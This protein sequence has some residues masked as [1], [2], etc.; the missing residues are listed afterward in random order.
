MY[1]SDTRWF[2]NW[3][4]SVSSQS[5]GREETDKNWQKL[6]FL[7]WFLWELSENWA[8]TEAE[9]APLVFENRTKTSL[10]KLPP[11]TSLEKLVFKTGFA[12]LNGCANEASQ[13]T[14]VETCH[15]RNELLG[16]QDSLR[17]SLKEFDIFAAR[18]S[19][20]LGDSYHQH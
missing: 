18:N 12:Q 1:T 4:L 7:L 8:K 19:G 13:P 15:L 5:W 17:A 6:G 16:R 14:R 10:G 3:F 9:T 2:E 20:L 11:K